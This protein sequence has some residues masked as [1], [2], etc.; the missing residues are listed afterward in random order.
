MADTTDAKSLM[1]KVASNKTNIIIGISGAIFISMF[2]SAFVQMNSFIGSKDDWNTLKPQITKITIL[3]LI[4]ILA[5]A[6]SSLVYF[7]QNA[8][9]AIYFSII[10]STISLGLAFMSLTVAAISR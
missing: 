6:S 4:G 7:T 8:S 10:V 2:I 3:V 5:F 1:T 9:M